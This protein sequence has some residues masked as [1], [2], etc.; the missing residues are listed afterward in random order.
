MPPDNLFKVGDYIARFNQLTGQN[1]PCG[2]IYQSLGLV[3]HEAKH[4]P[5]MPSHIEDIPMVLA[6]PDY[7]GK[8]PK[9][10]NSIELLKVL[11]S[12]IMVCVKLDSKNNYLFVASVYEISQAKLLNRLNSGRLKKY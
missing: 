1:L 8:H 6:E 12:N 9:E 5:N 4:H 11:N 3:K 2:S 10:L 7:I